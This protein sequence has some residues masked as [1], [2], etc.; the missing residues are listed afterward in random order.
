MSCGATIL[1]GAASAARGCCGGVAGGAS[2]TVAAVVVTAV[3]VV[4]TVVAAT[5]PAELVTTAT[6]VL[7]GAG[8]HAAALAG[9]EF[10]L[11]TAGAAAADVVAA[12]DAAAAAAFGPLGVAASAPASPPASPGEFLLWFTCGGAGPSAP[13]CTSEDTVVPL[14][15]CARLATMW[16]GSR[17]SAMVGV[18]RSS[19]MGDVDAP[20]PVTVNVVVAVV[21]MVVVVVVTVAARVDAAVTDPAGAAAGLLLLLLLSL[22]VGEPSV[23]VA[24][25]LSPFTLCAPER[26]VRTVACCCFFRVS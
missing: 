15:F 19:A 4:T 5:G 12:T 21:V 23:V 18:P 2:L 6:L 7:T 1:C 11:G 14:R 10:W 20:V 25:P 9:T 16:L 8:V 3:T 17:C 26:R 22:L 13:C 24:A